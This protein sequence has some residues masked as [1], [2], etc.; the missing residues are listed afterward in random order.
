MKR[1][2][3]Y[4]KAV[5]I[6]L[7][8]KLMDYKDKTVRLLRV[9][10]SIRRILRIRRI[11][12]VRTAS[13]VFINNTGFMMQGLSVEQRELFAGMQKQTVDM[14]NSMSNRDIINTTPTFRREDKVRTD[15]DR[16]IDDIVGDDLRTFTI[17]DW[18]TAMR[19]AVIPWS[20]RQS[21]WYRLFDIFANVV[22]D[23]H[24]GGLL[25]T[26]EGFLSRHSFMVT[27]KDGDR[28]PDVEKMFKSK[29]FDDFMKIV[30]NSD[31]YGLALVQLGPFDRLNQKFTVVREANRKHVRPDLG[32]FSNDQ[33]NTSTLGEDG[34]SWNVEPYK[35]WTIPIY[36]NN[37]G[38]LNR[39]VRWYIYKTDVQRFWTIYNRKYGTP[40]VIAKTDTKGGKF[41]QFRNAVAGWLNNSY[42]IIDKEDEVNIGSQ[43]STSSADLFEKFI[44]LADEQMSKGLL[45]S[46]M[47]MDNGSS[48][49]QS[50]VHERVAESVVL[51]IT[52]MIEHLTND[53]LIPRMRKIGF[54]L[55]PD[56]R[57]SFDRSEKLTLLELAD[58]VSKLSSAG[59]EFDEE[60]LTDRFGL[61]ITMKETEPNTSNMV[62]E[63]VTNLY[64]RNGNNE[65]SC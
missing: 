51:R 27:G 56:I 11:G 14:I 36:N 29:W 49:S 37:L 10:R 45:S 65:C 24:V 40:P 5:I 22:E 35:T 44:R 15:I 16:D 31:L 30:L 41:K 28:L 33:F 61:S 43:G 50:E 39:C 60:E 26:M 17:A 12:V 32:G 57:F 58:V 63:Q 19:A 21:S 48:R 64:R 18:R 3:I 46:T 1:V 55:P 38:R 34:K 25:D 4:I 53:E 8:H 23:P 20:Y 7:A 42:L 54:M 6:L 62:N 47:T 59:Y 2:F 52:K 9:M 13:A